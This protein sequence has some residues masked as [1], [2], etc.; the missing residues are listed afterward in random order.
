MLRLYKPGGGGIHLIVIRCFPLFFFFFSMRSK[1]VNSTVPFNAFLYQGGSLLTRMMYDKVLI[2]PQQPAAICKNSAP[3][4]IHDYRNSRLPYNHAEA[5]GHKGD[6]E[7]AGNV[8]KSEFDS[9]IEWQLYSGVRCGR[10]FPHY[11]HIM[12]I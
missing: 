1:R 11:H 8:Y 2:I 7:A 12:D 3:I 4:I 9:K 5:I 6:E 10:P